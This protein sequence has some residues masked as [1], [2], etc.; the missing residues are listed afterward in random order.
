MSEERKQI[1]MS[2]SY[3]KMSLEQNQ[4]KKGGGGWGEGWQEG[5]VASLKPD[6]ELQSMLWNIFVGAQMERAFAINARI[7]VLLKTQ[8]WWE[9]TTTTLSVVPV[10]L[11]L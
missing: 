11:L 5:T 2:L 4:K 1:K 10:V 6:L 7:C 9:I 8:L 3:Y